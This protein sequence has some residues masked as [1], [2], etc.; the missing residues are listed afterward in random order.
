MGQ[1]V[2]K[3]IQVLMPNLFPVTTILLSLILLVSS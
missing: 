2:K 1:Q 3:I